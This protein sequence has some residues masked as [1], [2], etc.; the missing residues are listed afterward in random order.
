MEG[1]YQPLVSVLIPVYNREDFIGDCI[2]SVLNQTIQNIEIIIV[3]N[4]STDNTYKICESYAQNDSRI[5]LFKNKENI[6]PIRNWNICIDKAHGKYGKI[7]FSDDLIR[8]DFLEKTIIYLENNSEVGFVFSGALEFSS[9]TDC[10]DNKWHF[11]GETGIYNSDTFIS[12]CLLN[13]GYPNS[14]GCALFRMQSLKSNLIIDIPNKISSNFAQHGIGSDVLIFLITA[15]QFNSYAFINEPLAYFRAHRGSITKSTDRVDITLLYL[16]AKAYY[17]ENYL[18]KYKHANLIRK[19]NSVIM[20]ELLKNNNLAL[21]L[22]EDFY[23][24]NDYIKMVN[25]FDFLIYKAKR[26]FRT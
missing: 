10:V 3:D 16:I 4:A 14:P 7:L 21:S 6:G 12:G 25:F 23:F 5:L 20:K 1:L 2:Q 8:N 18:D 24:I 19:F 26:F 22:I 13:K 15:I 11:V 17:V 9:N